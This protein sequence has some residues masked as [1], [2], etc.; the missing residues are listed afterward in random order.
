MTET[1][2]EMDLR[3]TKNTIIDPRV[4]QAGNER[5]VRYLSHSRMN[6]KNAHEEYLRNKR[7]GAQTTFTLKPTCKTP[8]AFATRK[9]MPEF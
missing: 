4:L 3:G 2:K 8:G 6:S 1:F 7:S 5:A 9:S